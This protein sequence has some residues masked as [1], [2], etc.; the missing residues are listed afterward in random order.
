MLIPMI[1]VAWNR[2]P[3]RIGKDVYE[4][5]TVP[6]VARARFTSHHEAFQ[7]DCGDHGHRYRQIVDV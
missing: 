3:G 2:Y 6:R 5:G 7:S 1:M 4:P